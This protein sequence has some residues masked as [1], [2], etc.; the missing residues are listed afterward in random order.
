MALAA[1]ARQVDF[2][3]NVMGNTIP[4]DVSIENTYKAAIDFTLFTIPYTFTIDR[5]A[6]RGL[7]GYLRHFHD[8]VPRD[9]ATYGYRV[10][11]VNGAETI[12]EDGTDITDNGAGTFTVGPTAKAMNQGQKLNCIEQGCRD[13][14]VCLGQIGA[15]HQR[16]MLEYAVWYRENHQ[17]PA[18]YSQFITLV[19]CHN[20]VH[21]D[22]MAPNVNWTVVEFH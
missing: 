4:V 2:Q 18:N 11:D 21:G 13:I 22:F 20:I 5:W 8:H 6:R 19:T 7:A 3:Q 17:T 10:V 1:V 16:S 15:A 9:V 12:Y 14:I